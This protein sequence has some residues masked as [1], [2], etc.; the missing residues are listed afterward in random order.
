MGYW[1]SPKLQVDFNIKVALSMTEQILVVDDNILIRK[2]LKPVIADAGYAAHVAASGEEA[3]DKLQSIQ[4]DLII[5]D[6]FMGKIGGFELLCI[7]KERCPNLPVIMMT[8]HGELESAIA[9]L[10]NGAADYLLKPFDVGEMLLRIEKCLE[11]KRLKSKIRLYEG[12]LPVCCH[13]KKIKIKE[14]GADEKAKWVSVEDYIHQKMNLMSSHGYCPEC[15][16]KAKN[17]LN[18]D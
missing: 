15:L 12:I 16:K 3:L 10:R 6:I 9:A 17:S 14:R 1:T 4:F 2:S 11:N 7:V 18:K 8:G 13:C 5:T